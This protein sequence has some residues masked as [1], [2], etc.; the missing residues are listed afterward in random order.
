MKEWI[1]RGIFFTAIGL[2]VLAAVLWTM[3]IF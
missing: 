2:E 3:M 1:A